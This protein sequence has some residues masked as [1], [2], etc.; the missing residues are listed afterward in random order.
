MYHLIHIHW[1]STFHIQEVSPRW[2]GVNPYWDPF[3]IRKGF[4]IILYNPRN[5]C[6]DN[7]KQ[8]GRNVTSKLEIIFF[9]K[10]FQVLILISNS[11]FKGIYENKFK[12]YDI[13]TWFIIF[14]SQTSW[15]MRWYLSMISD[16]FWYFIKERL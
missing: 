3:S 5:E 1:S 12:M 7:F 13:I 10:P 14:T 8:W 4:S 11:A 15:K 6:D 9:K 2:A 16:V